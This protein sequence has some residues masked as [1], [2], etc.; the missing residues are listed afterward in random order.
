MLLR[1]VATT[2]PA[3]KRAIQQQSRFMG[4]RKRKRKIQVDWQASYDYNKTRVASKPLAA[5]VEEPPVRESVLETVNGT[6]LCALMMPPLFACGLVTA[7]VVDQ[8]QTTI[9]DAKNNKLNRSRE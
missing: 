2:V 8:H 4:S 7:V 3:R 9:E 6:E 1:A 5:T